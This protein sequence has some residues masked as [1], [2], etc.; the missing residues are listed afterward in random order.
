MRRVTAAALLAVLV[1]VAGCTNPSGPS[2][3]DDVEGNETTT[4]ENEFGGHPENPPNG[5]SNATGPNQ[6]GPNATGPD[7]TETSTTDTAET[8]ATTLGALGA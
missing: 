1:A 2:N 5:T 6:T 7:A 3:G 4:T 8:K